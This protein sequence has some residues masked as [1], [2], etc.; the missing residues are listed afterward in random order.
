MKIT[1][2]LLEKHSAC[3]DGKDWVTSRKL[4]G[5]P[6][7]EFAQKVLDGKKYDW[8]NWLYNALFTKEQLIK[9]ICYAYDLLLEYITEKYPKD[10]DSKPL[11]ESMKALVQN[12]TKEN[13]E[14]FN[15]LY[16]ADLADRADLADLADRA[17]RAYRADRAY[18]AKIQL[19]LVE[20]GL[21]L[22]DE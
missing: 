17:Y 13:Y 8:M 22:I 5:L 1:L 4:L 16:L 11:L 19:K 15:K 2:E 12:P 7:R 3:K 18:R 20:Y 14:A 10:T 21:T 6:F 9:Y